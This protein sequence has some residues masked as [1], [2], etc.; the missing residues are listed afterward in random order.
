MVSVSSINVNKLQD[1]HA[2]LKP[3]PWR[4]EVVSLDGQL[5]V[6]VLQYSGIL[7]KYLP[8]PSGIAVNKWHF[9]RLLQKCHLTLLFE[10]APNHDFATHQYRN[11]M[12][13]PAI[14]EAYLGV[15]ISLEMD[16]ALAIPEGDDDGLKSET[17]V[18]RASTTA[19]PARKCLEF[20][21][22]VQRALI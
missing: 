13:G 4:V 14:M 19:R 11:L 10:T 18:S 16:S 17:T 3:P 2:S 8:V 9:R 7:L 20:V 15:G 12:E 22:V 21:F 5:R 1:C 6:F